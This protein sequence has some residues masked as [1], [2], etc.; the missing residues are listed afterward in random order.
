MLE[1]KWALKMMKELLEVIHLGRLF[2]RVSIETIKV[3]SVLKR[4][5]KVKMTQ[6]QPDKA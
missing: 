2:A 1:I 6:G 4:C 3:K 5:T